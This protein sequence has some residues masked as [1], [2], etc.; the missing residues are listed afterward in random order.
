MGG[1]I[2]FDSDDSGMHVHEVKGGKESNLLVPFYAVIMVGA[3]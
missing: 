2:D 3:S 1:R